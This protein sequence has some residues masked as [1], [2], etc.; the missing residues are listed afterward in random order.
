[1][2]T[3][4]RPCRSKRYL[5]WVATQPCAMCGGQGGDAHHI[6]GVGHLS[7]AGLKAS[8]LMTMPMCRPC[9]EAAHANPGVYQLDL[10]QRTL[11]KAEAEGVIKIA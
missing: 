1:M 4:H 8:D 7:G 2:N 9:H 10:I 5:N 11:D 6:K 3:K